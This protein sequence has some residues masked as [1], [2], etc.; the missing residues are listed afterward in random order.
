VFLFFLLV[1]K[2]NMDEINFNDTEKDVEYQ[3]SI[4][5]KPLL[6]GRRSISFIES[7]EVTPSNKTQKFKYSFFIFIHYIKIFII[8]IILLFLLVFFLIGKENDIENMI[9]ISNTNSFQII[10]LPNSFNSVLEVKYSIFFTKQLE[11]ITTKPLDLP[12]QP[13]IIFYFQQKSNEIWIN[14]NNRTIFLYSNDTDIKHETFNFNFGEN[15]KIVTRLLVQTNI[16]F[17]ILVDLISKCHSYIL[18]YRV[19]ISFFIFIFVFG[20]IIFDFFSI[21]VLTY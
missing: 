13:N 3:K 18:N 12:F 5:L 1:K 17:P 7:D 9:S 4:E 15:N 10:Y 2:I 8:L 19:L 16:Q 14:F 20:L 11:G 6:K 21:F